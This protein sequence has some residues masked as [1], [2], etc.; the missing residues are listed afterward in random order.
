MSQKHLYGWDL[1]FGASKEIINHQ[2]ANNPQNLITGF[3]YRRKLEANLGSVYLS[4]SFGT[5]QLAGG[6]NTLVLIRIPVQRGNMSIDGSIA[7]CLQQ[8]GIKGRGV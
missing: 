4:G 1:I 8:T 6:S 2:L 3:D 7:S 5:C